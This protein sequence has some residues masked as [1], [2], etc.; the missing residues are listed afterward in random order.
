MSPRA[1]DRKP[2]TSPIRPVVSPTVVPQIATSDTRA[3]MKLTRTP[4]IAGIRSEAERWDSVNAPTA[5]N[6]SKP[7]TKPEAARRIALCPSDAPRIAE[8]P[9]AAARESPIAP[10]QAS[11][12]RQCA[13]LAPRRA[14]PGS[15]FSLVTLIGITR[16]VACRS[17]DRLAYCFVTASTNLEPAAIPPQPTA[18]P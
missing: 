7:H 6:A 5:N 4:M 10:V 12:A 17:H 3:V 14:M 13:A 2:A 9:S 1:E 18:N 11:T 16:A 8:M 15:P